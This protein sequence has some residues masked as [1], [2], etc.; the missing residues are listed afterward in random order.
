[1]L[2][3]DVACSGNEDKGNRLVGEIMHAIE[4]NCCI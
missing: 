4:K 1:M 3:R 2:D